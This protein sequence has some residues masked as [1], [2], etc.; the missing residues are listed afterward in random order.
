[1]V[2]DL[3]A[4]V[5]VLDAEEILE[6]VNDGGSPF[7]VAS[8]HAAATATERALSARLSSETDG[9]A[10]GATEAD[11]CS[12]GSQDG[13][14]SRVARLLRGVHRSGDGQLI[15][16]SN[17]QNKSARLRIT[18]VFSSLDSQ[19][20][21]GEILSELP[22]TRALPRRVFYRRQ[23]PPTWPP[24]PLLSTSARSRETRLARSAMALSPGRQVLLRRFLG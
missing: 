6:S 21:P 4:Q 15:R 7:G 23:H 9:A 17:P 24:Q 13:A 1:M 14:E 3:A 5:V 2:C 8:A 16:L 18:M 11:P 20:L 10:E 22:K 12:N 19:V